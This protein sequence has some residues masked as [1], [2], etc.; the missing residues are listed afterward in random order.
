[1]NNLVYGKRNSR[2]V[3]RRIAGRK[4]QLPSR[5]MERPFP[6][7]SSCKSCRLE[8][9]FKP[10]FSTVPYSF[11]SF[12]GG[13]EGEREGERE[14]GSVNGPSEAISCAPAPLLITSPCVSRELARGNSLFSCSR[15]SAR[16]VSLGQWDDNFAKKTCHGHVFHYAFRGDKK[17]KERVASNRTVESFGSF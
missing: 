12:S 9:V 2:L 8:R 6:I 4:T 17:K 10:S 15:I 7:H 3:S 14:D 5:S 16:A 13:R 11:R 1:M